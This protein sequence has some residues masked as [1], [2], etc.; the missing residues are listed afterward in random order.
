MSRHYAQTRL[1]TIANQ[2]H[3]LDAEKVPLMDYVEA[4]EQLWKLESIVGCDPQDTVPARLSDRLKNVCERL[5]RQA[6]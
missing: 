2:Q 6:N 5:K 1:Q 3:E 4:W